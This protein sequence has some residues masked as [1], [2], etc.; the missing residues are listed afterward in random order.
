[1]TSFLRSIDSFIKELLIVDESEDDARLIVRELLNGGCEV[2]WER[3]ETASA[4]AAAA[5]QRQTWD[6]VTCEW[7]LPQCSHAVVLTILEEHGIDLP[8]IVVSGFASNDSRDAA[9]TTNSSFFKSPTPSSA[10]SAPTS[11]RAWTIC[12]FG[13]CVR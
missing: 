5:L 6:A 4:L 12:A 8:V 2:V 13:I 7:H 3:V 1:M 9:L 10:R 11:F